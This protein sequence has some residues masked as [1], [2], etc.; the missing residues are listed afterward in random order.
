MTKT[1]LVTGATDGI[2]LLTAKTLTAE[3]HNVLLHGR[4]ADKLEATAREVGGNPETYR[5]DLSRLEDVNALVADVRAKHDTLDV[6]IN[7]AGVL[8]VPNTQTDS[9]L[10]VRFMVNTIAPWALTVGL[11]P[12]IPKDGRVVSLSSAAQ[13]P[14]NINAML[15]EQQLG[16]NEAYAQSKLALT[17]WSQELAREHPDGP[18]FVSVNPGSLLATKMVK[19]SYGMAG[20]DLR[21]GADI[22][23]RA[24]VS[25]EFANASGQYYDNDAGR[26]AR[27]HPAAADRAHVAQ[28]MAAIREL[29]G[30]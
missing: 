26:I 29:A 24:A 25:D 6:L 14:V 18:M 13:A 19:E 12:I 3:G 20:N 11:L 28:L 2:G 16:H 21:I 4:S 9:G 22:L 27:P 1:I 5:A 7:N 15:G 17:I 8:K 10:D 23:R 30:A